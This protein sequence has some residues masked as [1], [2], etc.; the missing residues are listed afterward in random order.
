M[1]AVDKLRRRLR[2]KDCHVSLLEIWR[3]PNKAK[4]RHLPSDPSQRPSSQVVRNV[5]GRLQDIALTLKFKLAAA[6][7]KRL[8]VDPSPDFSLAD[9]REELLSNTG[10]DASPCIPKAPHDVQWCSA[11]L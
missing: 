3:T 9:P 1:I 6:L 4:L 5:C 2:P 10:N 11:P 7:L 8:G